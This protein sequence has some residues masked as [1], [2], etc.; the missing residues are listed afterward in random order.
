[1]EAVKPLLSLRQRQLAE[2]AKVP[3]PQSISLPNLKR[4][5]TH[6]NSFV[7]ANALAAAMRPV[8]EGNAAYTPVIGKCVS[9][10]CDRVRSTAVWLLS[11][12]KDNAAVGPLKMALGDR[13]RYIRG[14]AALGLARHGVLAP[15]GRFEEMFRYEDRYGNYPY[16]ATSSVGVE[17]SDERVVAALAPHAD[18]DI[19][20]LLLKYPITSDDYEPRQ[21]IFIQLGAS[22]RKRPN[23]A[24]V[25][26]TAYTRP[27][28]PGPDSNYGPA[29]FAQEVFKH[30]GSDILPLLHKALQSDDRVI[31]SNAARACGSVGDKSS[32]KPL[33]AALDLESG[34]SRGSIVWALGELKAEE[35]LPHL[36]TLYV[37]ARNDEKRRRGAGFR[38]AQMTAQ[39][40]GHFESIRN[41][42]S[43]SADWNELKQPTGPAPID[44]RRHEKLLS[45][46]MVLDA[47]R[48]IGPAASQAF[49]RRL[50]AE[51]DAEARREA[52]ARMAE[53]SSDDKAKNIPILRN[54]LGDA[55]VQVRVTSAVSLLLLGEKDVET[56]IVAWLKSPEHSERNSTLNQL[57]RVKDG[58]L[59][60]FAR[61]PL[62]TLANQVHMS[63]FEEKRLERLLGRIPRE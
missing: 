56:H 6:A 27:D 47:V 25:L 63:S 35:A 17:V 9:D 51:A 46:Q 19:F 21:K 30:A 12:A 13:D 61:E 40:Q 31:R 36:A 32:I 39:V 54:L 23:A 58:R 43:I 37:D 20:E 29:R 22:L 26:L 45:T 38:G 34:F 18:R 11:R 4:L 14:V 15:L 48:K 60:V 41:L 10:P 55:D 62:Q 53:G 49:Y 8:Q 24:D 5:L 16:G 50:A 57:D 42:D 3:V 44:P 28:D 1:V 2:A 7:R 59:L 33:I 52:A